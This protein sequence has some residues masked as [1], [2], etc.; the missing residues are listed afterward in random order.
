M[1]SLSRSSVGLAAC[2]AAL[3]KVPSPWRRS[4]CLGREASGNSGWSPWTCGVIWSGKS[5]GHHDC[6]SETSSIFV[7]N[8]EVEQL[9]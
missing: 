7:Q 2:E 4:R 9:H 6:I 1:G 5:L 3:E 8:S